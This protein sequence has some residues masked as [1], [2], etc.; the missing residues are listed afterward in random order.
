MLF[1]ALLVCA[2]AHA[3]SPPITDVK[4]CVSTLASCTCPTG[5]SK[6]NA[7]LNKGAKGKYIF[8]CTTTDA[9]A[10]DPWAAMTAIAG[11]K[12][13]K[14]PAGY[15]RIEQD[16]SE[17]ALKHGAYHYL[18]YTRAGY[19]AGKVDIEDIQIAE[20]GSSSVSCPVGYSKVNQDLNSGCHGDYVFFCTKAG[21]PAPTPAPVPHEAV[22]QVHLGLGLRNNTMTV[23]WASHDDTAADVSYGI[24]G[25]PLS[26]IAKGDTRALNISG[27][28]N[29]HVATMTGLVPDT[30]YEYKVGTYP[31]GPPFNFT[32]QRTRAKG[33]NDPYNH[34]IFGDLGATHGFSLCAACTAKSATCDASTCASPKNPRPGLGLISE[35]EDADMM[36]H[37]GDF[38]YDFDSGGGDVGDQFMRNVEQVSARVPY[39][40]SI[41]NHE[42]G[43]SNL[44]HFVERYRNMPANGVPS[45]FTTAAGESANNLYFSWDAGLVHYIA[46]STEH[47]FGVTDKA[48]NATL[49]AMLKWLEEDLKKANANRDNVPWVVAHGHR[50]I[51]CSTADD[52]DCGAS[53]AGKVRADLEPLF[54]EYGL[55]FWINGKEWEE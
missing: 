39:M 12:D 5:Y 34:I 45:T 49:Q 11:P 44:A 20:S 17:G 22:E 3:A 31:S 15:T 53:Q 9:T 52:K 21:A 43:E 10:G 54:F 38:A 27:S 1:A 30:T 42:D 18:C 36:L 37:V 24:A 26:N 40:V 2:T 46:L 50:D 16:L 23:A 29:T 7:D 35:V 4:F 48:G 25:Q 14:C 13:S 33:P 32:F 47:W 55:D 6:I 51:Y 28:R 8:T 19:V 41:G